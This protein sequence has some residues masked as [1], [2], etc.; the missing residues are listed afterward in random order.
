MAL[1]VSTILLRTR[2][3]GMENQ[4]EP[5]KKPKKEP[6][7]FKLEDRFTPSIKLNPFIKIN[8]QNVVKII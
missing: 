4:P 7:K 1:I 3:E 8:M 5:K 2:L 6:K